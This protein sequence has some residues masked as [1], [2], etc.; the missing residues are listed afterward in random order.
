MLVYLKRGASYSSLTRL[1][2]EPDYQRAIGMYITQIDIENVPPL[3]REIIVSC[4]ER[5]NLFIGPNA[6]GKTTILRAMYGMCSSLLH[7]TDE[8]IIAGYETLHYDGDIDT[9]P[10]CFLKASDDW[11]RKDTRDSSIIAQT[12]PVLYIPATRVNL[13]GR[14]IFSHSIDESDNAGSDN[15]LNNLFDTDSGIFNG[16]YVESG[17]DW[18]A[19]EQFL[20]RIQQGELRNA[21]TVGYSCARRVCPEVLYD[22]FPHPF[23]EGDAPRNYQETTSA[24]GSESCTTAWGL[25]PEDDIFFDKPQYAGALSSGTQSTLLWIYALAL[26]MAYHYD[27]E[28]GWEES[29]RPSSLLTK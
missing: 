5:V 1:V 3:G 26:K 15:P 28:E 17:V 21:I 22:E 7:T 19:K 4:D 11:P 20:N 18:L 6:S 14:D 9:R 10:L 12:L 8:Y 2:N 27:F 25:A 23:I 13:R 16:Q 29:T 24:L